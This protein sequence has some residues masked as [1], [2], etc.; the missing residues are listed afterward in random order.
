MELKEP[1]EPLVDPD[2]AEGDMLLGFGD[3]PSRETLSRS[4][5]DI[6]HS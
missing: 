4:S 1:L 6:D 3:V 5:Q 2:C